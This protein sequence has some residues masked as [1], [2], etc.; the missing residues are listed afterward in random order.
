MRCAQS[1]NPG[2]Q[3]SR[4][5]D[6]SAPRGNMYSWIFEFLDARSAWI[7]NKQGLAMPMQN[8]S[9]PGFNPNPKT[10]YCLFFV[11]RLPLGSATSLTASAT[12]FPLL[13]DNFFP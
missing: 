9:Q 3:T 12:S 11:V 7:L 2:I 6:V 5:E 10:N 4:G 1:R 8:I 13:S